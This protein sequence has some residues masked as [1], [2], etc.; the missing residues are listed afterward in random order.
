MEGAFVAQSA[1]RCEEARG[2]KNLEAEEEFLPEEDTIEVLQMLVAE[3]IIRTQVSQV[4][5]GLINKK[6]NVITIRN[7]V[8]MHMNVG[9][10]NIMKEGKSQIS[11]PTPALRQVQ[12]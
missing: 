8:I 9:R 2:E 12:C 6:S 5:R 10:N 1:I 7:L 3:E 4:A 11:Q